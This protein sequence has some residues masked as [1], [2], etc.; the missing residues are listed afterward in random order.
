MD[1]M[2]AIRIRRSIRKYLSKPIPD[3]I[4]QDLLMAMRA[5]P[6]AANRQPWKF[7]VVT[8]PELRRKIVEVCGGQK[9]IAEAPVL[10]VGCGKEEEAWHGVGGDK[11]VSSLMT[12]ISIAVDHLTLAATEKGIGSCWIQAFDEKCIKKIL[13]VPEDVRIIA[14]CTLGYP[15]EENAFHPFS[16]EKRKPL[17]EIICYN[18]YK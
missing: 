1:V 16:P 11:Q 12:D 15:A 4:L 8:D 13:Q 18:T 17:E 2:Q 14:L 9:F 5:A 6:S 10:I 3:K 7:I